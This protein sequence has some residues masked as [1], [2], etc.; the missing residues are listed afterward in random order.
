[1]DRAHTRSKW[2]DIGVP[3]VRNLWQIPRLRMVLCLCL[4]LSSVPLHLL[5]VVSRHVV[6]EADEAVTTPLSTPPFQS[7][8]P[9]SS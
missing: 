3:S 6:I 8:C 9:I 4:V 5:Y 7:T 1:M 2:L